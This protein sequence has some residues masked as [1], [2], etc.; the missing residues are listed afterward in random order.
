MKGHLPP[1]LWEGP[2]FGHGCPVFTPGL[3]GVPSLRGP[4][5]AGLKPADGYVANFFRKFSL[6]GIALL[7][8]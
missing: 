4:I 7:P 1:T 3:Y 2:F 5:P 8:E 6:P